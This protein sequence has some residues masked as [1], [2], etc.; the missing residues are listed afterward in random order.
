M[1]KIPSFYETPHPDV[2]KLTTEM[3]N[4]RHTRVRSTDRRDTG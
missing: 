2:M 4:E 3:M 1:S